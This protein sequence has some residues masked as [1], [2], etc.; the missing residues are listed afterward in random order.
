MRCFRSILFCMPDNMVGSLF[1]LSALLGWTT[2]NPCFAISDSDPIDTNRPSF[3]F[4]PLVLPQGSLQIENGTLFQGFHHNHWR[5]DIPETQVRVGLTRRAE[6]QM[7]VPNAFL[8]H[9][10]NMTNGKASDLTEI[11]IKYHLGPESSKFNASVIADITAPTGSTVVSGTGVQAAFRLP[12]SY[13]IKKWSISGMQSFLILNG[14]RNLQYFPDAMLS[15]N[16]SSKSAA[17]VEYGG[18]FTQRTLPVN[19]IHFGAVYKVAKHQQ[20]DMQFGF[21]LNEAAPI[22]FVGAGYSFRIDVLAK[23]KHANE[24][25]R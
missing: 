24:S 11:G 2:Q 5:Y 23:L 9:S 21:G 25:K 6:L 22:A 3:M 18:Y 17:F 19:L 7:Y 1:L 8:W 10:G 15:R 20:V 16:I 12:Y 14:S 4:S 13:N